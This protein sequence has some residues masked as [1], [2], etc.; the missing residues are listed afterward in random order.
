MG[1][2]V[3]LEHL[4]GQA[5]GLIVGYCQRIAGRVTDDL[6]DTASGRLYGMLDR[7]LAAGHRGG[8]AALERVHR[9]PNDG[10]NARQ[11]VALLADALRGDPGFTAVLAEEVR[12]AQADPRSPEPM[13]IQANVAVGK[14]R[15]SHFSLGPM[16]ITNTRQVRIAFGGIAIAV[17]IGLLL[18]SSTALSSSGDTSRDALDAAVAG[19]EGNQSGSG[20]GDA[21]GGDDTSAS[22]DPARGEFAGELTPD[23]PAS[24]QIDL[25][26]GEALRVW[27]RPQVDRSDASEDDDAGEMSLAIA[28]TPPLAGEL[29][30]AGYFGDDADGL[31]DR[32]FAFFSA[33]DST[34]LDTTQYGTLLMWTAYQYTDGARTYDPPF[35]GCYGRGWGAAAAQGTWLM[36]VAPA[37]GAYS[38]LVSG[39]GPY[40]I[41]IDHQAPP[42][43]PTASTAPQFDTGDGGPL[44]YRDA[45]WEQ[46]LGFHREF[47]FADDF[48]PSDG[49]FSD[50]DDDRPNRTYG[51]ED[52]DC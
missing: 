48:Y 45:A 12:V 10:A 44:P 11:L 39:W 13:V 47:L 52:A 33:Y 4:A 32:D 49:F 50:Y 24:R 41:H 8:Q 23:A 30:A 38:L 31:G 22:N 35:F 20:E 18:L 2:G 51:P 5:V 37:S 42:D 46:L 14:M 36:F 9:D 43:Q 3:D 26:A 15:R 27:A 1:H 28:A 19:G 25:E 16:T 29:T 21:G 34:A 6:A 40:E 7:W 17:V